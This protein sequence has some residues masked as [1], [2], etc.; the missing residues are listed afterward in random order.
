MAEAARAA[1][2]ELPV[3]EVSVDDLML[4]FGLEDDDGGGKASSNG[5]GGGG[6]VFIPSWSVGS[7]HGER[8]ELIALTR[9]S[10]SD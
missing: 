4:Q 2:A 9:V 7:R 10:G 5:G 3:K 1:T 6:G 8:G